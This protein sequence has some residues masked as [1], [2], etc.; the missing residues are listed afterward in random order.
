MYPTIP[1]QTI[2][3]YTSHRINKHFPPKMADTF[4]RIHGINPLTLELTL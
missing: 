1:P 4:K 3:N 2:P